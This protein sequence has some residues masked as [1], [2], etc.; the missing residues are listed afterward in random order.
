MGNIQPAGILERVFK[1]VEE[2]TKYGGTAL[3][4]QIDVT[5]KAQVLNFHDILVFIL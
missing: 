5:D 3:F 4:K 2:I 1:V